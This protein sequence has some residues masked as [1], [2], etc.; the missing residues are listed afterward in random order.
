MDFLTP[1]LW[2]VYNGRYRDRSGLPEYR[3]FPNPC[4]ANPIL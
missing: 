2:A 3:H 4:L 1:R